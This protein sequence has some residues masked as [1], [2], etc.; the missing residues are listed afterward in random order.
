MG[1]KGLLLPHLT[2][3]K[4]N[5]FDLNL[6]KVPILL[7]SFIRLFDVVK[8]KIYIVLSLMTDR[9]KEHDRIE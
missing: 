5:I 7:L 2:V 6:V 9:T 3:A 4:Q 1:F 8:L